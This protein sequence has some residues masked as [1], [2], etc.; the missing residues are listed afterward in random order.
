MFKISSAGAK[1]SI[2]F[3][4]EVAEF[5]GT[6]KIAGKVMEDV[7]RVTGALPK[8]IQNNSISDISK[9]NNTLIFGTIGQNELLEK[10]ADKLDLEKIRGKR[11]CFIFKVV[12]SNLVIA[13]SDK[14]GTIYGLF[15]L[16]KLMGVSP[17]VDWADIPPFKKTSVSIFEKDNFISK[18][19]SVRFR[20]FFINDEWPA[21][22]NWCNKRFGG[23]NAKCYEHVF[24]LLLRMNG[25]YLWPAMWSSRFSDDGPGLENAELANELGVIMGASHH[26]PCC[27]AGEEYR[28]LRGK[29][30]KYGDAWN[31][32]SNEEGITKFWEDGL[33]RNGQYENVITVGMRGEADTAIMQNATLKDNI[34]LLRDVLRTQNSLIRKYV[35]EDLT[36]V[37]RML[38]LYKEVEPYFYGDKHT[39]GLMG[40]KEL[41][42]VTLML[43][44]DN[45]GNLRTVPTPK[46]REH[47][48]G[49]GMYYHFDYHGW[50]YSYEWFNTTHLAKVKE[51][52][53]AAWDFGIRDLWIVNIGDIMTNEF[54]LNFFLDLAYDFEKY[55]DLNYSVLDYTRDWVNFQFSALPVQTRKDIINII[56]SYTRLTHKRRTESLGPL[57]YHPV[58]FGES[59]QTLA[60]AEEIIAMC[61]KLKKE[62]ETKNK[63]M[64]PGLYSQVYL[65]AIANM[66]VLRMQLYSGK[67]QWLANRNLIACGIYAKKVAECI[68]K[69]KQIVD[70]C[71][72]ACGGKWYAMGWSE[73]FGF[74]TWCEAM[75]K[76]PVY[77]NVEPVRKGR[78]LVWIE[79]TN[80]TTTGQDWTIRD[81]LL[82]QFNNPDI[83]EVKVYVANSGKI[84]VD[85][86]MSFE[87]E[88]P[89]VSASRQKFKL[90][91]LKDD[92]LMDVITIKIDRKKLAASKEKKNVLSIQAEDFKGGKILVNIH[93][94]ASS[95]ADKK[96]FADC[97]KETF[98]QTQDYISMEAAHFSSASK[99]GAWKELPGYGKTLSAMKVCPASAEYP[100]LKEAPY[101]EYSFV[102]K[103][104][105]NYTFDFYSNPSNPAYKDNKL[106]F[107][108][109]VNGKTKIVDCV[110]PEYAVGD[111]QFPW[112][113][114]V[115][116]NIRIT[117][118][119]LKCKKGLNTLRLMPVTPG[120]VLEKIVIYKA[121]MV[122]P[123]SY[124]GAPETYRI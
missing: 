70:E 101:I 61:E 20:G 39:K 95:V 8:L 16:S 38:A 49:Y 1:S 86:K 14:R 36:K 82:D 88:N 102:L 64:W 42:G 46:M 15:H 6:V 100:K 23:F 13:G 112:G 118:V 63:A 80:F 121:G 25:N 29:N 47:N 109:C 85:Y 11:E 54:P 96:H 75:N 50:P 120:F 114:E 73:H 84:P 28:Y 10:I 26:E 27:R 52:M 87:T 123:E 67:N 2:T 78:L 30:S 66:N 69:D 111:N 31:F 89:F 99:D 122:M 94:D 119:S 110:S 55:S 17:L 76:Y 21:F 41:E 40:D 51:Q 113:T 72:K 77:Y 62:N 106:Q 9:A 90:E 74:Q 33:K 68:A 98:I 91:G 57:T 44:D 107:A 56:D 103:D 116:N 53:S 58:N 12:G 105:G 60:M 45:H 32:R 108:A 115:T 5:S 22:G 65:P 35:N 71:D 92:P 7:K 37:P 59:D 18:E 83:N 19:P 43:C 93:I 124:L 3:Y 81:L 34:K 97:P 4:T 104:K 24:E 48:G 117:S 79:G